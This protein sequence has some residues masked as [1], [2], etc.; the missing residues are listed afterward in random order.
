[1]KQVSTAIYQIINVGIR[2]CN[3]LTASLLLIQITL[4]TLIKLKLKKKNKTKCYWFLFVSIVK[5]GNIAQLCNEYQN[6][7]TSLYTV[8][9]KEKID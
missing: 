4:L 1:M 6:L 2:V 7:K 3:Y 9:L 5:V 8:R